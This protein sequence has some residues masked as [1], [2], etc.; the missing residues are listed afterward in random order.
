MS[1]VFG[2]AGIILAAFFAALIVAGCASHPSNVGAS[3]PESGG[4]ALAGSPRSLMD[5]NG[6]MSE[7]PLR[8]GDQLTIM[9]SDL[10]GPTSQSVFEDKIKDD[11]TVTLLLNQNF[12]AANKTRGELEKE[13]R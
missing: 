1:R 11:G 4:A 13:A 3:E 10:P 6:S 5:T 9:F 12:T 7:V 8:V 2:Q